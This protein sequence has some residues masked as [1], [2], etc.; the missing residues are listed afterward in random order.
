[1]ESAAPLLPAEK[2]KGVSGKKG[3]GALLPKIS[4][5]PARAA[6]CPRA[7]RD[8]I[9][10]LSP[11]PEG[12]LRLSRESQ[13][14]QGRALRERREQRAASG[15]RR[16]S[17]WLSIGSGARLLAVSGQWRKGATRHTPSLPGSRRAYRGN[18]EKEWPTGM[19]RGGSGVG[20]L[21]VTRSQEVPKA[22]G[23]NGLSFYRGLGLRRAAPRLR[24]DLPRLAVLRKCIGECAGPSG[25]LALNGHH[26]R[27]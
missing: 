25:G 5:V 16:A 6:A 22:I 10:A 15:H 17:L 3:E 23:L 21:T 2:R 8:S 9:G 27:R 24:I 12:P 7:L 4:L 20:D 1:M 18:A 19:G 13:D 11:V 14:R 26:Q